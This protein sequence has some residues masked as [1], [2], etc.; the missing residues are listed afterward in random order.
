MSAL[1]LRVPRSLLVKDVPP[2]RHDDIDYLVEQLDWDANVD[3]AFKQ[4]RYLEPI[5][6]AETP[7]GRRATW[8]CC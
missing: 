4:N 5:V 7:T 2:A 8:T 6:T 1:A 3:P